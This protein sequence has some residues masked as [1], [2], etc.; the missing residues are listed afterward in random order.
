MN[1]LI[2]KA[3]F[4]LMIAGVASYKGTP[5]KVYLRKDEIKQVQYVTYTKYL[6]IKAIW[7]AFVNQNKRERNNVYINDPVPT[8]HTDWILVKNVIFHHQETGYTC[9][10]SS[11]MEALSTFG[12]TGRIRN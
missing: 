12:V 8:P 3:D 11:S 9:G 7:D 5:S 6:K 4:L 10:P 2:L 1:Y